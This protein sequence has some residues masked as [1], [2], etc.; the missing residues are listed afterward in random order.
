MIFKWSAE[1]ARILGVFAYPAKSHFTFNSAILKSLSNVGHEITVI[2]SFP[3]D[4][5]GENYTVIDTSNEFSIQ[6]GNTTYN[7][8][9]KISS[10]SI[11]RVGFSHEK[12]ICEKV[13][14]RKEIQVIYLLFVFITIIFVIF[15]NVNIDNG[16]LKYRI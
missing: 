1:G 4:I 16:F 10:R 8:F 9:R 2:T 12:P 6:V 14:K 15:S 7:E 3:Q 11:L 5:A 13:W